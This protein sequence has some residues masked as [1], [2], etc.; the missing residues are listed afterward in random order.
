MLALKTKMSAGRRKG[1]GI[2]PSYTSDTSPMAKAFSQQHVNSGFTSPGT[3]VEQHDFRTDSRP[4]Y[5]REI[6]PTDLRQG[7]RLQFGS[8]RDA[9]PMRL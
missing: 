7:F 9:I 3:E 1:R 4:S 8:I 2:K 5:H 6:K